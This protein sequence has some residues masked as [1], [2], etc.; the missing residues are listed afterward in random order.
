V[1]GG[2][3]HERVLAGTAF[4]AG[5]AVAGREHDG[6]ADPGRGRVL[7]HV[8]HRVRRHHDEGQ[9]HGLGQ[10]PEAAQSRPAEYGLVPGVHRDH[11]PGEAGRGAAREDEL[12]PAR[13]VRRAHHGEAA[14]REELPQALRGDAHVLAF[15]SLGSPRAR[16]PMM[17]RWISLVPE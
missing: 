2:L 17:V 5:L 7:D 12:R 10:V 16:S 8:R 9:V 13:G 14:R 15:G 11:P 3:L 1:P 6:V 4:R